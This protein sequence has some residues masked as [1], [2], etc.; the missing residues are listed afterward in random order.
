MKK[1]DKKDWELNVLE[2]FV[3]SFAIGLSVYVALS[4]ILDIFHFYNFFSAYFSIAIIDALFIWYLIYHGELN[5][6]KVLKFTSSIRNKFTEDPKRTIFLIIILIL[7]FGWQIW[8]QWEIITNEYAIPSKDTYVWLGQSWYL[9]ENGYIWREHM[10]FHYPKGYTFFLAGPELIYPDWRLAYFYMKFG[11]IPLFSLYIFVI[12][13]IL[14]RIFNSNYMILIGLLLTLLS[15]F[16]FSR[17]NSN[18]SSS[19]TALLILI[20]LIILISRCP[21]Y[22]IGFFVA[23]VFLFNAIMGLFYLMAILSLLLFKLISNE[24]GVKHFLLNYIIIPSTL[25]MI[26][27]IP[28]IIHITIV[29]QISLLDLIFAYFTQ[30]G[31]LEVNLSKNVISIKY[32]EFLLQFRYILRDFIPDND[33]ISIF[34]DLEKRVLSFYLLF[35]LITLFLPTK[36]YFKKNYTDIINFGKI[37][38]LI[39]IA[40]YTAEIIFEDSLNLFTQSLAWFKWRTVEAL[41]GP[42]IILACFTIEKIIEKAKL[43]TS[44]LLR[45]FSS[46]NKLI[47]NKKFFSILRIENILITLILI[48][49]ISSIY[50]HQRIYSSYYFEQDQIETIF[51]IKENVP[52]NSKIL[53]SDFND[54]PNCLYNLLSTYKVYKWDFEFEKNTFNETINYILEKDIEYILLDY[55]MIN[56]TEKSYFTSY[57]GFDELYENDYNIVFEVDI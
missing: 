47:H 42:M 14:K 30:L 25:I 50:A 1:I 48:S 27:L 18:V 11:G 6:E 24:K 43:V 29:K 49:S 40:F 39:I 56:S 20:S 5:R 46:Y 38:L 19:I 21:F 23:L 32:H 3:V 22:L 53:V 17:F 55:T 8:I 45:N 4:F 10:P 44:Y 15:N 35:A 54:G 31:F 37:S 26:L 41:A 2:K 16:L 28:Y 9:L 36:K 51:Y 12:F 34:L 52:Y 33:V 13:L 7:I 57:F